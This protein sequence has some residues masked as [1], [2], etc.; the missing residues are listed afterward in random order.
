MD[1][2]HDARSGI[3][4]RSSRFAQQIHQLLVDMID[5]VAVIIQSVEGIQIFLQY[6][7]ITP[8]DKGLL[9]RRQQQRGI[10]VFLIVQLQCQEKHIQAVVT[11]GLFGVVQSSCNGHN[12]NI[13]G[14]VGE[15]VH[16]VPQ[17]FRC[18]FFLRCSFDEILEIQ[19]MNRLKIKVDIS[20]KVNCFPIGVFIA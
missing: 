12:G 20:L 7:D 4:R 19:K 1:I 6:I 9:S 5:L 16:H 13:V 10:T 3:D 2:L 17:V 18:L 11:D 15:I 8:I 14:M